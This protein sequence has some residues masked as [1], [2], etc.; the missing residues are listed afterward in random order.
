LDAAFGLKTAIAVRWW[1]FGFF[2][3]F[4]VV[5]RT[6][7]PADAAAAVIRDRLKAHDPNLAAYEL[8]TMQHWVDQ[9]SSLMRIRT[10]LITLLGTVALLLGVIGIY[11]VMSYLVAQRTHEFGIRIALGARPGALPLGVVAQ[12][13]RYALAGIVMGLFAA[14]FVV[15]RMRSLLFEVDARDPATFAAVALVVA[16]V[17]VAASY[18][19][20]RRAASVDP[21]MLLRAE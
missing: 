20:A 1:Q 14:V 13:L 8:Q 12:G 5:V 10:R 19:P 4:N 18:V 11:G 6:E 16:L 15:D 2:P 7:G 21:L 17:A 9:S 3:L